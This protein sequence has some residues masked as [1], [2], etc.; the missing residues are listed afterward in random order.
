MEQGRERNIKVIVKQEGII[1]GF[2]SYPLDP[3][4]SAAANWLARNI[5]LSPIQ[6]IL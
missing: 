5:F 4:L 6:A 3:S 1:E 2:I